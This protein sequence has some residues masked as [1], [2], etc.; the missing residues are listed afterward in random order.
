MQEL[1]IGVQDFSLLRKENLLYVDKTSRLLELVSSGRRY[2]LSRPRR[3]GKSL[4]LSTLEA[5]F[6]GKQHLFAGL[7]AET[8]VN[9]QAQHP[10]PVL[11]LDISTCE[12]ETADIFK[13]SLQDML[14]RLARRFQITLHSQTISGQLQDL[15]EEIFNRH[16]YAVVL[17]DEY[18][19]PILDSISDLD[20]AE[21]LRSILRSFY[22]TL[23]GC[24]EYLRFV[25]LTGI[26]KFSKAGVFS[27]LN[28]LEDISLDAKFSDIV[29]YTQTELELCFNDHINKA[30]QTLQLTREHFLERLKGYYDGFSFDGQIKL[31]NPF[32][33]MQCLKKAA[34]NNY[35]YE[36]GSPSFI[37]DYLKQHQIEEPENYRHT[38][39]KDDFISSQDIERADPCSFLF[40][41]GYLTIEKKEE[42]LLT[43]DFPNREVLD[44]L[45]SMYLKLIY[46]VESY[47][48][49]GNEIW[50]ALR[51]GDIA[52][53]VRLY[54]IALAAVPY[55]DFSRH[56]NESWYRSLF[57]M[58][59]RGAG[60]IAY[61]E[62]HTSK[63]RADVIIQFE[64][65]IVILEFKYAAASEEVA[66]K[67]T[68]GEKQLL[69]REYAKTYNSEE[70]HVITAVIVAD[71]EKRQ[72][73]L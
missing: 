59:L 57:I 14:S 3:F 10:C 65:Q 13:Q 63:G 18:D 24:D 67:R 35:W 51:Q 39:V 2:F 16:G 7:Q 29:G 54:N 19:K 70:R 21:Q 20:Q 30:A 64:Q 31:Y 60:I 72:A 45:S 55:D 48:V 61:S 46:K 52:E 36:S 5:M 23:K 41:S 68:E 42:H 6:Q 71:A 69:E 73:I 1:P 56:Q 28:N 33:I 58:L 17:I 26:S 4:T 62:P 12:H 43:L 49:L 53:M 9:E 25:M 44:S 34:F 40:Q 8:W 11:R 22:T 50:A 27:A 15:I 47:A 32:S 38:A 37:V 66:R